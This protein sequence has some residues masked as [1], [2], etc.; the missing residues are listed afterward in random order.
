LSTIQ[1]VHYDG[2]EA[3]RKRSNFVSQHRN[4]TGYFS[5]FSAS[6]E[7]RRFPPF[8]LA[9]ERTS[10]ESKSYPHP[11]KIEKRTLGF[12]DQHE[13]ETLAKKIELFL[14]VL[15]CA[16]SSTKL[17]IVFVLG[18]VFY[19]I[20]EI[21]VRVLKLLSIIFFLVAVSYSNAHSGD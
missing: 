10:R 20:L 18:L 5:S 9:A 2:S 21:L 3:E 12:L 19:G 17:R 16:S 4:Y 14:R 8:K 15:E 13:S 1:K 7:I 6:S 11:Q